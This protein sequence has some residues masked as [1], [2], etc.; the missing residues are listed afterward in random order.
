MSNRITQIKNL[1]V[2]MNREAI[3]ASIYNKNLV[4]ISKNPEI[5]KILKNISR[6]IITS[7]DFSIKY[8]DDLLEKI[9]TFR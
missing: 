7:D 8:L 6:D 3:E 5:E 9:Y 4:N 1:Q 2:D